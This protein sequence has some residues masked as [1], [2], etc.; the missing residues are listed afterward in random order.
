MPGDESDTPIQFMRG[1]GKLRNG[2]FLR[3]VALYEDRIVFEVFA[4]RALHMEDDLADLRFSDDLGTKYEI[5]PPES[6]AI[7]GNSRIEF[8][9][10]VP[11]GWSH[12]HLGQPGW[13]HH[14]FRPTQ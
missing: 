3:G 6:G 8:R 5:V 2:L 10:A 12:L 4:S 11:A 13:G 14:V 9:P 1:Q 7:E